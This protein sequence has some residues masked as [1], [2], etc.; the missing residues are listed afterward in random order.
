MYP[1][2]DKWLED[3]TSRSHSI[4]VINVHICVSALFNKTLRDMYNSADL[5]A[6]DSMPFLKWARAFY[7]KKSDRFYAPDLMLEVSSKVK[8][9]GYTFYLYGGYPEAPLRIEEYLHQHYPEVNVIG[10]YSPPFRPLSD[11]EDAQVCRSINELHPDFL[12][13]GLGSPKQDVWIHKHL[14]SI[15]G[16]ILVPSG[17]TFDFFSGRIRQAPLWIQKSGFEW[18]FRLTQDFKRLWMRYTVYNL[19]FLVVFFLQQ[20]RVIRFDEYGFLRILGMKTRFGNTG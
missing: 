18:L 6:I 12:W 7:N 15:R 5:V 8:E 2:F 9:K 14:E 20:I 13:L 3:K 4:A 10:S 1:F 17:A 19:V 16:C 11:E